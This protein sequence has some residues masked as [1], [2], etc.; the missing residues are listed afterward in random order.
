MSD[1]G[2]RAVCLKDLSGIDPENPYLST[3]SGLIHIDEN[4]YAYLPNELELSCWNVTILPPA[5]VNPL[6]F[7]EDSGWRELADS[8][9]ILLLVFGADWSSVDAE[10][11]IARVAK[12]VG[13]K[14]YFDAQKLFSYVIGYEEGAL[15][16]YKYLAKCPET[17]AGAAFVGLEKCKDALQGCLC[18]EEAAGAAAQ[19]PSLFITENA[20]AIQPAV[21]QLI[22]QNK[23]LEEPFSFMGDTVYL[24]NPAVTGDEVASQRIAD[25]IVRSVSDC[26]DFDVPAAWE[27]LHRSIRIDGVGQGDLH[28]YR[29]MEEWGLVRRELKIDGVVRH[30]LEYVPKN[31][32]SRRPS[33]PLLVFLHGGSQTAKSAMYAAEWMNV[34]EARDFVVVFPTGT[35]RPFD[36]QPPHPA[37]NAT[38]ASNLF[39]DERFIREMVEDV[40]NRQEIDRSRVYVAGH[41]MGAAMTQRCA[42]AMPDVFAA[43]ASNS[44]VVV[45]GFMGDFDTPGVR[46]D[47][48]MPVFI[49]MGEHDVGGG[50]FEENKNAQRTV[51]YWI[52]RGQLSPFESALEVQVGRYCLSQWVSKDSVPMLTYMRTFDKPHCITPQDAWLY[53]DWFFSR[54]SR[55]ADGVI[56][57]MGKAV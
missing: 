51:E 16:A 10:E 46:E 2:F 34:A 33:R 3:N 41:S 17:Y 35:M 40:S 22:S 39:D 4:L 27:T 19:L 50:S 48:A 14:E 32:V 7:L 31:N 29:S 11:T 25:V 6:R 13:S 8:Q 38:R 5:G 45:G 1:K 53:Y 28:P 47:L 18:E 52:K 20:E 43:A 42:L 44:G 24:P 23:C 30:W 56:E 54:F 49:Q 36:N 26:A 21:S 15:A 57:Y 37:W 55:R 9:K 12:Q